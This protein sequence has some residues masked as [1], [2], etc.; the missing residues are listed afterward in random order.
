[1]TINSG[2]QSDKHWYNVSAKTQ[3]TG[4]LYR[5]LATAVDSKDYSMKLQNCADMIKAFREICKYV[6]STCDALKEVDGISIEDATKAEAA[7]IGIAGISKIAETLLFKRPANRDDPNPVH[8][9]LHC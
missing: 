9:I 7:F 2:S 1:M 4:D 8:L 5:D 6:S 3:I